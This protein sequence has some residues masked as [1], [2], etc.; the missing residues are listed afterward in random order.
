MIVDALLI[1]DPY[2]RIAERIHFPDKYVYL[3][4]DIMLRIEDTSCPVSRSFY[5]R[6]LSYA[7]LVTQELT[8][9]R[10]LLDRIRTRDLYKLVDY[11]V[12]DWEYRELCEQHITPESVVSAARELKDFPRA[13]NPEI[14][15]TLSPKH[16]IV[17]LSPMHYGMKEKNPLDSIKFYSKHN[18]NG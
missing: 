6:S 7:H 9:A 16:V 17:D 2:L 15:E 13:N 11:K 1:A 5:A 12:F 18:P 4:D 10:E 3:T 8:E 14:V